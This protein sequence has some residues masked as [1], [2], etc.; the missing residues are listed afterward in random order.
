MNNG[1]INITFRFIRSFIIWVLLPGL[2]LLITFLIYTLQSPSLPSTKLT[3]SEALF[4]AESNDSESDPTKSHLTPINLPDDWRYTNSLLT[5]GWYFSTITLNV[6]PNRLWGIYVPTLTM[7]AEVY[8]NGEL[9][10]SGGSFEPPISRNWNRPLYFA[11]PNGMLKPGINELKIYVRADPSGTGYL[12][13]IYLGPDEILRKVYDKKYFIKTTVSI[14]ITSAL[15]IMSIFMGGLWFLRRNDSVYGWFAMVNLIWASHNMNLFVI[16]IP[17]QAR[18]WDWYWF[19]T[20]L[21]FA[22]V[23]II[24]VRRF[25]NIHYQPVE[26]I[27]L[28][29]GLLVALFLLVLPEYWFYRVGYTIVDS[30][31]VLLGIYPAILLL[32]SYWYK[33]NIET[34]FLIMSGLLLIFLGINDWLY[35]NAFIN[36]EHG[37]LIH[38]AAPLP[39]LLF[40]LILLTRFVQALK[41]SESLNFELE[42]RVEDKH[43][44]L[45]QSYQKL[46]LFENERILTQERERI[47]RDMHD[48]MG[49]HLISTLSMV[50]ASDANKE[51]IL[52]ALRAAIDDLRVMIDSLDP[53]EDDLTTVL[54]M[55][56]ARI[57]PRLEQSNISVNWNVTDVPKIPGLGPE[58]VLQVLR[59]LQ[60]AI[61][62]VIKHANA[63]EITVH[64]KEVMLQDEPGVSVEIKDNGNGNIQLHKSGRGLKNMRRRAEQIGAK[65]NIESQ[66]TG[67]TVSL[68][69]SLSEDN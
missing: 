12:S 46:Q 52:N 25:L 69:L 9:L 27:I 39:M 42:Q 18:L 66:A 2:P 44:E 43:V 40:S 14:I 37:L 49:G 19:I 64:T 62:N 33:R 54:A 7:N 32:R 23:A 51:E 38:N 26:R 22:I 53:V 4:L 5:S 31:A 48:G 57:Q 68:W 55:Y 20:I 58:K 34:Y 24:F 60:E 61:S 56:R 45:E 36:R 30:L 41:E 3:I 15:V 65:F 59:V 28:S 8:L 13:K 6:P 16:N 67:T 29:G 10:G 17:V 47:M 63:S 50:E 11:I 1:N 35:V 21:W